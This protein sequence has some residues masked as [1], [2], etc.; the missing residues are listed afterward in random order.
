MCSALSAEVAGVC[1]LTDVLILVFTEQLCIENIDKCFDYIRSNDITVSGLDGNERAWTVRKLPEDKRWDAD[2][3]TS[4]RGSPSG[5]EF[6][7]RITEGP[8][9][10]VAHAKPETY[11]ELLEEDQTGP[12]RG[13]VR[14]RR[15]C[16][17]STGIQEEHRRACSIGMRSTVQV[18]STERTG[19]T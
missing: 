3:A 1:I 13:S 10:D 6:E 8:E 9:V 11:V 7:L 18:S 5:A 12:L 17:K 2:A 16:A 19:S 14:L 4:V 15:R